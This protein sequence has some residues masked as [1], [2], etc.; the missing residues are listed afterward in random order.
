MD[1]MLAVIQHQ[2]CSPGT[3]EVRDRVSQCTFGLLTQA[4]CRSHRLRDERGFRK[5]YQAYQPYVVFEC[6]H[7]TRCHLEREA[8]LATAPGSCEGQQ[9]ATRTG[10]L[11][12]EYLLLSPNKDRLT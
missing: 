6:F 3:E 8:S 4:Q 1:E 11:D 10:L 2:Q 7:Q 9:A 5:R 12:L